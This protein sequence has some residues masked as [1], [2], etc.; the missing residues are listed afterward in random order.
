M[1][2]DQTDFIL[3]LI[4]Q[5][6]LSKNPLDLR[7]MDITMRAASDALFQGT[8]AFL[9]YIPFEKDRLRYD[10]DRAHRIL[11]WLLRSGQDPDTP[12]PMLSTT[13]ALQ[14]S[15]AL[16]MGDLVSELLRYRASPCGLKTS[17]NST[18]IVG[19]RYCL[20]PLFLAIAFSPS[21]LTQLQSYGLSVLDELQIGP[22]SPSYGPFGYE[23]TYDV[24]PMPFIL[25]TFEG[26]AA[27]SI[28]QYLLDHKDQSG[29]PMYR[30]MV[31]WHSLLMHAVVRGNL[32]TLKF[33]LS[34]HY[35]ILSRGYSTASD[36]VNW[37]NG[38]VET[39]LHA[40]LFARRNSMEIC[41]YL[42][43]NGAIFDRDS[44]LFHLACARGS[45]EIIEYLH[46]MG[47]NINKRGSARS[48]LWNPIYGDSLNSLHCTPL[49]VILKV[50]PFAAQRRYAES[51]ME[52]I[53]NICEY[54]L[55]NGSDVPWD[56]VDFAIEELNAKL[57]SLALKSD[58]TIVNHYEHRFGSLL[59]RVLKSTYTVSDGA[60]RNIRFICNLLL[61]FGARVEA[62]DASR[63]AFL[64]DWD[65][66][67][68]LSDSDID[69]LSKIIAPPV[70]LFP[71]PDEPVPWIEITLLESAILSGSPEIAKKAFDL[72]PDQ[73]DTGALCA[74]TLMA[75]TMGNHSLVQAL[76]NNRRGQGSRK[77]DYREMTA[78]G[79]AAR[80]GDWELLQLLKSRLPW[81]NLAVVPHARELAE[82][83]AIYQ[84]VAVQY[85]DDTFGSP[86][87]RPGYIRFW[88][89]GYIGSAQLFAVE[90]ESRVFNLFI[91]PGCSV[92]SVALARLVEM[93]LYDRVSSLLRGRHSTEK[94]DNYDY[95]PSPMHTAVLEG[96]IS[97][98]RACLDLGSDIQGFSKSSKNLGPLNHQRTGPL[99][100]SI[101][102]GHLEIAE[103]LL[104][105]GAN[106]NSLEIY[107]SGMAPLTAACFKG[108]LGIVMK[109][110]RLGANPNE[111]NRGT[112]ALGQAARNGRLDIVH[113]L[114][115]SGVE[116]EGSGRFYYLGATLKASRACHIQVQ[117]LLE[118]HRVWTKRDW[119]LWNDPESLDQKCYDESDSDDESDL[120]RGHNRPDLVELENERAEL[121]PMNI[122]SSSG[123]PEGTSDM[124]W[125]HE[126]FDGRDSL[127][128]QRK[129]IDI[130]GVSLVTTDPFFGYQRGNSMPDT[131]ERVDWDDLG[132]I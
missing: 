47:A 108:H 105:K 53:A 50:R 86:L 52:S 101:L 130:S 102:N 39:A 32:G 30:G 45:L 37:T 98:V 84:P 83:F 100:L 127:I 38:R 115:R 54:L 5:S 78:V 42:I 26:P 20:H 58:V 19:D 12:I 13:T 66:V 79:I 113:L 7:G 14:I 122:D 18:Q 21:S 106:V 88:N 64:G 4:E 95:L 75:S 69:G 111:R 67:T 55:E 128:D 96:S 59:S 104:N 68:R 51:T 85:D 99:T 46:R 49:E 131:S 41:Q 61:D 36:L 15:L 9:A 81:S 29:T 60:R 109:L 77:Q 110:L 3:G 71:D 94:V 56:L 31:D 89:A 80:S 87:A 1:D 116:T 27:T 129:S 8:L 91:P 112:T 23:G 132:Y 90:A 121:G 57:L 74:A 62:G 34:R 2:V 119:K 70:L 103:L 93:N 97:M 25:E 28:V 10:T 33:L 24:G 22:L 17:G 120:N 6:G 44:D 117:K 107:Y 35:D 92:N 48:P 82:A 63:A 118:G 65:L 11:S 76:L 124:S 40:S 126:I 72:D 123:V 125:R 114:L 73:Y 16:G 43:Q